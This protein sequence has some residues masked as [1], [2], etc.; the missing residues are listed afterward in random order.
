M[1]VKYSVGQY[2]FRIIPQNTSLKG[3]VCSDF[4]LT[5]SIIIA[6][7]NKLLQFDPSPGPYRHYLNP[8]SQLL[9]HNE[10]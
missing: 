7:K 5:S 8:R 3:F 9:T 4:I 1:Y 2:Q 10:R 6:V